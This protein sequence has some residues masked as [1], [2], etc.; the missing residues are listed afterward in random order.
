M[1]SKVAVSHGTCALRLI[2]YRCT[3]VWQSELAGTDTQ[4]FRKSDSVLE[5]LDVGS[6]FSYNATLS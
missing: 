1:L 4:T 3:E 6:I 2:L 5:R